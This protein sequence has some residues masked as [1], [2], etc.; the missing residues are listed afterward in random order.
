MLLFTTRLKIKET[1]TKDSFIRLVLEWNQTGKYAENRIE[2]IQW[3]GEYS[4]KYGN[5]NLSLEFVDYP[6]RRM[7]AVR[8]EKIT[9]DEVVWDTDYVLNFKE[10]YI[11]IRLDRTYREDA[12]IMDGEFSTPHFITLLINSGY[13]EADQELPVLR[14]P[15]EITDADA[16][17]LSEIIEHKKTYQ[18]PVVYVA[19]TAENQDVLDISWLASGLKGAAHVLVEKDKESCREC[20]RICRETKEDYGAVRIYYPSPGVHRKRFLFRSANGNSKARLEK[21]IRHVI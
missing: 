13:L 5:E 14:T 21:V 10:R 18:L 2:N 3:N 12:L 1:L 8:Y 6:N 7:M 11:A 15:V 9:E 16:G 20:N 17:M 4:V 19:K